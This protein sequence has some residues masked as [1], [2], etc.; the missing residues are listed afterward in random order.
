MELEVLTQ[1]QAI[2]IANFKIRLSSQAI[3]CIAAINSDL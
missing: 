2:P 3:Q 1:L